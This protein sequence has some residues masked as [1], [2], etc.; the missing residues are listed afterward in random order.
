M[1]GSTPLL[2]PVRGSLVIGDLALRGADQ[3]VRSVIAGAVRPLGRLRQPTPRMFRADRGDAGRPRWCSPIRLRSGSGLADPAGG[4]AGARSADAGR[5]LRF[6]GAPP[7]GWFARDDDPRDIREGL[8]RALAEVGVRFP[9]LRHTELAADISLVRGVLSGPLPV[10]KCSRL[11]CAIREFDD[12]ICSPENDLPIRVVRR[13]S[14]NEAGFEQDW[15]VCTWFALVRRGGG[16]DQDYVVY[17]A[18]QP[19]VC[20]DQQSHR[21]RGFVMCW[22]EFDRNGAGEL[23]VADGHVFTGKE[24]QGHQLAN[25]FIDDE[26]VGRIRSQDVVGMAGSYEAAGFGNFVVGVDRALIDRSYQQERRI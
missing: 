7:R 8:G 9:R 24:F 3:A 12:V 18:M 1:I 17:S 21:V 26:S 14:K 13:R 5:G 6:V 2:C 19:S 20:A 16:V 11:I 23:F 10:P 22:P 15:L 4:Y 25:S